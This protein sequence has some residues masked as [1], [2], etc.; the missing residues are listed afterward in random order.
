MVYFARVNEVLSQDDVVSAWRK[1]Q[2]SNTF[3][4]L[5]VFCATPVDGGKSPATGRGS[6]VF[7]K[8]SPDCQCWHPGPDLEDTIQT[9]VDDH[10][11]APFATL[12]LFSWRNWFPEAYVRYRGG[13][14]AGRSF[15]FVLWV[16][17]GAC[18]LFVK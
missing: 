15:F 8:T 14:C 4:T 13:G 9:F 7:Q 16:A 5:L 11:N 12:L 10:S 17:P 18:G 3:V 1:R 6:F 2:A